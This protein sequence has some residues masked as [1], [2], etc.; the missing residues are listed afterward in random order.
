M[1]RKNPIAKDRNKDLI[2]LREVQLT[3]IRD[4]TATKK[5]RIEAS[6]LLS[7]LHHALAPEKVTEVKSDI[8]FHTLEKPTLKPEA[9]DKLQALLDNVTPANRH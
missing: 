4:D 9:Q 2:E 6:K 5:D 7:R 8:K 1:T 3:I